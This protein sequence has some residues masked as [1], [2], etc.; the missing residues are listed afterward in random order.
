MPSTGEASEDTRSRAGGYPGGRWL[1]ELKGE[2]AWVGCAERNSITTG[3]IWI[4]SSLIYE[5]KCVRS[6]GV[7]SAVVTGT[8]LMEL[9]ISAPIWFGPS[10]Y[11]LCISFSRNGIMKVTVFLEPMTASTTTSLCCMNN[12]IVA[13][14]TG[15][16]WVRPVAPMTSRLR[17]RR[18]ISSTWSF[19]LSACK[20]GIRD[21]IWR[22]GAYAYRSILRPDRITG[23]E[24]WTRVLLSM[25]PP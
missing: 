15:V 25:L 4:A 1:S 23:G 3:C 19:R 10:F 24:L 7:L 2:I 12:G 9:I 5:R 8:D 17:E 13:A 6:G 14:R 20:G 22:F 18:E 21:Q 16:V 11:S